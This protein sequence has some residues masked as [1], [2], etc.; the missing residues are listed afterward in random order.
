MI[1]D[2]FLTPEC[3]DNSNRL[4]PFRRRSTYPRLSC[5]VFARVLSHQVSTFRCHLTNG[6][7]LGKELRICGVPVQLRLQSAALLFLTLG[8]MQS[9]PCPEIP[10]RSLAF[11][12]RVIFP[13]PPRSHGTCRSQGQRTSPSWRYYSL[14]ETEK[15]MHITGWTAGQMLRARDCSIGIGHRSG[16]INGGYSDYGQSPAHRTRTLFWSCKGGR[17]IGCGCVE[18]EAKAK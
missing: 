12:H 2:F 1:H 4:V 11:C 16:P 18:L 15:A 5:V 9:H 17:G 13:S 7:I 3:P 14:L 10:S 6:R 8:K